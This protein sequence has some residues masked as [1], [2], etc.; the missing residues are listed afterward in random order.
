MMSSTHGFVTLKPKIKIKPK[1][2]EER[3]LRVKRREKIIKHL[4]LNERERERERGGERDMR[5]QIALKK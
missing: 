1:H 4:M 5:L 2:S 3:E